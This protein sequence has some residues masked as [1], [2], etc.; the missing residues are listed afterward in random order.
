MTKYVRIQHNTHA[1]TRRYLVKSKYQTYFRPFFFPRSK[2]ITI[3]SKCTATK[4]FVYVQFKVV[5]SKSNNINIQHEPKIEGK[6]KT[7]EKNDCHLLFLFFFLLLLFMG[8]QNIHH[9]FSYDVYYSI[10]KSSYKIIIINQL[11]NSLPFCHRFF[12]SSFYFF[13][14]MSMQ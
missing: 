10:I 7:T 14:C 9:R 1:R 2:S 4:I 13:F 3:T 12:L 5:V 6:A 11:F 8:A